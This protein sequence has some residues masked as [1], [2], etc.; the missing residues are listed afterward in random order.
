MGNA[1]TQLAKAL[2]ATHAI[3]TTTSHA[4]AEQA[5]TLGFDEVI[6]L[7]KDELREGVHRITQG[8]GSTL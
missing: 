7:S 3:S 4:K 1:V 2:G 8:Y 5:R 6:D